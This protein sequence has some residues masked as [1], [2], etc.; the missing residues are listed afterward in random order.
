M[1]AQYQTRLSDV[2]YL[3]Q[4]CL[5]PEK[6]EFLNGEIFAMAGATR[7]HNQIT[8]N[9]VIALGSQLLN[10]P[11]SVYA[12]DMKVHTRSE[13]IS[14]Y[15]YPD[16]VAT[17]GVEQFEDDHATVLLNPL[18][19]IEVLSDST[20]AYDR[21]LKFFH[22]QLIPSLREYLLV[23]Q[24]YCRVEQYYRQADQ[25]WVYSEYHELSDTVMIQTLGCEVK[26]AE[27]YRRVL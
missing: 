11:C 6:S 10:K 5:A 12:S 27:I 15:S 21:G 1:S 4:E 25:Q 14:K 3:A 20:E 26:V 8:S 17:C 24:D 18:L 23:A 22:Y 13:S 19:I 16:V 7:A 2:D 9:L